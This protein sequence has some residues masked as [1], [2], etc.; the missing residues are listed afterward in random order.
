MWAFQRVNPTLESQS[1]FKFCVEKWAN[2]ISGKSES[3]KRKGNRKMG[4][5]QAG[6][7]QCDQF[8]ITHLS[9]RDISRDSTA[10]RNL[11]KDM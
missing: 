6:S 4:E 3:A 1:L 8:Y 10:K 9:A 2:K 5:G 11:L 7:T